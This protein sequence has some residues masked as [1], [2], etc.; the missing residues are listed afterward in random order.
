VSANAYADGDLEVVAVNSLVGVSVGVL[1]SVVIGYLLGR[2]GMKRLEDEN[3]RLTNENAQLQ[4]QMASLKAEREAAGEKVQW[5]ETAQQ[6]LREAFQ[7]LAVDVLRGNSDEF[8]SKASGRL[9]PLEKALS[10]L[11]AHLRELEQKR[12]GA[13]QGLQE[14][15]RQLAQAQQ[16]LQS[17]ASGLAQALK[18][19]TV[20]GRWGEY[21]LR[22]VVEM[23][24]LTEHVSFEEQTSAGDGRPDMLVYLPNEGVLPVDA[25]TPMQAYIASVEAADEKTRADRL[26]EHAKAMRARVNELSQR[27]YAEQLKRCPDFVVMFVPN[28]AC[29]SS[30]F[31]RDPALLDY[32]VEKRVLLVTPVTLLALLKTVAYGWQQHQVA[33]NARRIAEQGKELHARLI[34]F[35]EHLQRTGHEL[36]SAVRAYNEAVGSLE[37]RLLPAAAKLKDLGAAAADLPDVEP[38]ERQ[39]RLPSVADGG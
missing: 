23:A 2:W 17:T 5:V 26:D 3:A 18:S 36:D 35:V 33:E 38:V 14:Q 8:V 11:E 22:R 31:S 16:Q 13:Y 4:L 1:A 25:K 6:Q 30:A 7:S 12:E 34:K 9:E 39:A 24:G 10:G 37:S 15:L 29:L 32:A 20:R 27:R 21:E 28:D 19:P